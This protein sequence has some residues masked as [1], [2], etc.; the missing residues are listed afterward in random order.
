M[1][2]AHA[3][4]ATRRFEFVE[5]SSSKFWEVRRDGD[6]VVVRYGRIGSTGQSV[7]KMFKDADSADRHVE[8]LVREKTGKGYV[9]A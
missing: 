5:G 7:R 1:R 2:V 3:T 9:E 4:P 6:D 8:K